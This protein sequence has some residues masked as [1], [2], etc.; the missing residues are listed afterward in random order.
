MDSQEI[1]NKVVDD[2]VKSN[3]QVLNSMAMIYKTSYCEDK[4]E[5]CISPIKEKDFYKEE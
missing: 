3:K 2:L 5:I 4:K 1:F